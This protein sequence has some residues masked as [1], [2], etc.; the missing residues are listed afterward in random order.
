LASA[1]LV[2]QVQKCRRRSQRETHQEAI[3]GSTLGRSCVKDFE[4]QRISW[5]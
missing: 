2:V 3:H 1:A 4:A 5:R